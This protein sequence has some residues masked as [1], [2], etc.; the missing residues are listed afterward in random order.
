MAARMPRTAVFVY[1]SLVSPA[2]A[3]LTLGRPVA[4][5][6]PVRLPGWRRLWGSAREN[7]AVEKT[8]ARKD[9][10]TI[11]PFILGLT[12]EPAAGDPGPTGALLEATEEELDRL[13]VRE[14]RYDREDVTAILAGTGEPAAAYDRVYAYRAKREHRFHSPPPGA[15][16]VAG[17]VRAVEAAFD[18]L[19]PG[20]LA[21]FRETT[22]PPPVEVIDAVLVRDEIPP[23]NP[24]DW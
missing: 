22:G 8:F 4:I 12:V 14:L 20:E 3:E 1:G 6:A 11:P 13:D 23:G 9:D 19:G 17:Y 16:I 7:A 5:S 2:S 15:A 10:G 18:E 24:R 21:L